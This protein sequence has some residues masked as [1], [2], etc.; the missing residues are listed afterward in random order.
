MCI[1]LTKP[2]GVTPPDMK[3]VVQCCKSNPHGFSVAWH[4]DGMPCPTIYKTMKEN[5]LVEYI[6]NNK[7]S[8]DPSISWMLHARIMSVGKVSLAN[9]HC[10]REPRLGLTFCHN[11]TLS[12]REHGEMTD[13]ETFFRNIFVPCMLGGGNMDDVVQAIIGSSKFAFMRDDGTI[14]TYGHYV[15]DP[16]IP[17]CLF[18]NSTYKPYVYTAPIKSSWGLSNW[19]LGYGGGDLYKPASKVKDY[20]FRPNPR[21]YSWKKR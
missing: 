6:K 13:S 20:W 2:K 18:S 14:K 8:E 17:G 7:L 3:Y 1:I 4:K 21:W 10:W 16:D 12:I 11:G 5:E 19:G 9:C 15:A